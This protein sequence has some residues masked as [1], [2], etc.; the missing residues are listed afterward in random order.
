MKAL[1]ATYA[2][3]RITFAEKPPEKGPVVYVTDPREVTN[4]CGCPT[5]DEACLTLRQAIRRGSKVQVIGYGPTGHP[6]SWLI[7]KG[8]PRA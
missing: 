7:H 4:T 1:K 5:C 3:G 2:D 6:Q 8:A